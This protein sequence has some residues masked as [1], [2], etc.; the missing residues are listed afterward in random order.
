MKCYFPGGLRPTRGV[1]VPTKVSPIS[2]S[3]LNKIAFL[4]SW[5]V[6][7]GTLAQIAF[8]LEMH[9]NLGIHRKEMFG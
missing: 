5:G 7:D 9:L 2:P 8:L 3:F 4:R 6:L 1:H